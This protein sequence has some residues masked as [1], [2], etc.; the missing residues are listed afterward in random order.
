MRHVSFAASRSAR[1]ND[2]PASRSVNGTKA[3]HQ[4][5]LGSK[6]AQRDVH[7][8]PQRA[9]GAD[10]EVDEVHAG[11]GKV[12]GRQ[13]G[14]ARHPVAGHGHA[15]RTTAPDYFEVA[16]GMRL[17]EAPF[18]IEHVTGRQDDREALHPVSCGAVLER[19]GAGGVGCDGPAH[20]G[21]RE[22]RRR[23]VVALRT[24]ER[25]VELREGDAGL[26]AGSI[27][28][29][30]DDPIE[31][32]R[33]QHDVAARRGA[34]G[35]RRLRPDRQHRCRRLEHLGDLGFR[36]RHDKR[37]CV[38]GHVGGILHHGSQA[39][40]IR[41][42]DRRASR[43]AR[44]PRFDAVI[45][46]HVIVDGMTRAILT[47]GRRSTTLNHRVGDFI[48][49]ARVNELP[50][51]KGRQVTVDGRWVALFNVDGTYYAID[52]I[53]LHQGGPLAEGMLSQCIVTCPWHGWQFDITTGALVQD[54]SVGVTRHETRVI[55]DEIQVRL[56]IRSRTHEPRT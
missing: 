38:P 36:R 56:V 42:A 1:T 46:H 13:L 16:V 2:R 25:R 50:T 14:N 47:R 34:A 22:G 49:V 30:A 5:G 4:A 28:A 11:R 20:E 27:A 29:D 15:H 52:A 51:K 9:L 33:A 19:R 23:R 17:N 10:E 41:H 7:D 31:T 54:P 45:G 21:A 43:P 48:T 35:Q 40:G 39:I 8:D 12:T 44:Q 26:D 24:P 53:C 6:D 55:G 18:D 37:R 3:R 32:G